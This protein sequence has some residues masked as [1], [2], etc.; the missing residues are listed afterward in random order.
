MVDPLTGSTQPVSGEFRPLA[1]Q[2]YRPLQKTL[3]PNEFWAAIPDI[4]KN[5]TIV[6]IYETKTFGFRAILRVP[7]MTFNSMNMWVDE[8]EKTIYFVYRGH[9]LR[10]PLGK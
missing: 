9:L 6:G 1:Q 7:K 3:K 10:M 4:D 2:T 5:E 8:P